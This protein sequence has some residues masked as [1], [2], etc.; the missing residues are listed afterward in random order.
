MVYSNS[1]V[2]LL[3]KAKDSKRVDARID[4]EIKKRAQDELSRHGLSMS[5][6]IRIVVTSVANDGLPKHFGIPNEVVNKSLMEMIDDL[7]DQKKLP[8]AHN[9]QELE[10]LLN[11][12]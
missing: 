11:D 8:H 4:P 5:E 1:E 7:S 2:R 9:L 10:K 6:F 3:L 12:D